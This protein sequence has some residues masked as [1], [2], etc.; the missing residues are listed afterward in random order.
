MF[1]QLQGPKELVILPE[2][3][4]QD[5]NGSQKSYYVASSR[6]YEAVLQGQPL[7]PK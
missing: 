3:G 1:N 4:H 7:P 5:K 2:A 6:W